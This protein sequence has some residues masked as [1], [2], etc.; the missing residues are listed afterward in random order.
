M[1][2]VFKIVFLG[3]SGGPKETNLS[4]YFLF[5][6]ESQEAI[7]LDAGSLMG[8]IEMGVQKQNFKEIP[9]HQNKSFAITI[10]QDFIK[11]YLISHAHLD[12]IV[13]L[14]I[15]SQS[16]L[17]KPILGI[18]PTI[19]NLRDH[20]FNGK[21][22]PNYGTEGHEPLR[23]YQYIRLPLSKKT[24]IPNTNSFSVEAYLLSHPRNYPSSAFLI[25]ENDEYLLYFGDTSADSM[26]PEKRL[27]KIWK[28]ITPL[29]KEKKLRALMLECSFC[30]EDS[31][32]TVF[33]HLDTKLMMQEMHH[34]AEIS[35]LSLKGLKVIVT[36]RKENGLGRLDSKETIAKELHKENTL[37]IDFIFPKQGEAIYL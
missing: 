10:L 28:R 32:H 6:L 14:V 4:G 23:Q 19:D 30:E 5:S 35:G 27:S 8:G 36:H 15:N 1:K 29:L 18:D 24:S 2:E 25:E 21:I 20:I 31:K 22:W 16:D 13:G 7:V 3:C 33:G 11:A 12:H 34:L 37:G 9:H 26:E 17:P